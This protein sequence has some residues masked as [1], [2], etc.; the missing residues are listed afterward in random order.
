ML[1]VMN[2]NEAL[3]KIELEKLYESIIENLEEL[4]ED[5]SFSY[6]SY[7]ISSTNKFF[8]NYDI[9]VNFVI[10]CVEDDQVSWKSKKYS[11]AITTFW[12]K[13]TGY[14]F[15]SLYREGEFKLKEFGANIHP[16]CTMLKFEENKMKLRGMIVDLEKNSTIE[17]SK[18][19]LNYWKKELDNI[20]IARFCFLG[21]TK[22]GKSTLLNHLLGHRIL[23]SHPDEAC[24]SSIISI[25]YGDSF[26]ISIEFV[27]QTNIELIMKDLWELYFDDESDFNE[28]QLKQIYGKNFDPKTFQEQTNIPKDLND[29]ISKREIQM[30]NCPEEDIS[31]LLKEYAGSG[32]AYWR[33]VSR[34]KVKGPF[35]ILKGNHCEFVDLP[36]LN[37]VNEGRTK[38]TEDYLN[39]ATYIILVCPMGEMHSSPTI[40]KFLKEQSIR[41]KIP[42]IMVASK[43]DSTPAYSI[44]DSHTF[45]KGQNNEVCYEF[46]RRKGSETLQSKVSNVSVPFFAIAINHDEGGQN[47]NEKYDLRALKKWF[48]NSSLMS[49]NDFNNVVSMIYHH[50]NTFETVRQKYQIFSFHEYEKK[51]SLDCS[52]HWKLYFGDLVT[53]MDDSKKNVNEIIKKWEKIHFSTLKA[54]LRHAGTFSNAKEDFNFNQDLL[55]DFDKKLNE[56]ING[57][58][59]NENGKSVFLSF[60]DEICK[61]L[62][63]FSPIVELG[64]FGKQLVEKFRSNCISKQDIWRR[65][66]ARSIYQLF[67][68]HTIGVFK[69]SVEK[70][71]KKQKIMDHLNDHLLDT[72]PGF[73]KKY[74]KTLKET[75]ENV[76]RNLEKSIMVPLNE[77]ILEVCENIKMNYE[78]HIKMKQD[79]KELNQFVH[80]IFG[81]QKTLDDIQNNE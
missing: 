2:G 73:E 12:L 19:L 77:F 60:L 54:I 36:G 63:S 53:S 48:I 15:D 71:S 69:K 32:K 42:T 52:N 8:S 72:S 28:K 74:N 27:E 56:T 16:P 6:I 5:N 43:M 68:K 25:S 61:D 11:S 39:E 22:A 41:D 26:D 31:K 37:D 7:L 49:V 33:F 14:T 47:L 70:N 55:K 76:E 44:R 66:F 80:D 46:Q 67:S 13:R 81:F 23:P 34:I 30:N 78:A 57:Y 21:P 51:C 50:L 35:E 64:V 65:T 17:R 45:L 62:N 40:S 59:V 9:S 75:K 24:T 79:C 20:K 3:K 38:I 4:T 10:A 1:N 18:D 58:F 29:I